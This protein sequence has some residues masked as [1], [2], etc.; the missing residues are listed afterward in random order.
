VILLT[1][2]VALSAAPR[3]LSSAF[4]AEGV[5]RFA[6]RQGGGSVLVEADPNA[7]MVEAIGTPTQWE[8]G[9]AVDATQ[10]AEHVQV[11]VVDPPGMRTCRVD[12]RVVLPPGVQVSIDTG[13]G[14]VH[15]RALEGEVGVR[16]GTG[17][18][19]L[20]DVTGEI[21]VKL[22][23]GGVQGNF[24]GRS[25]TFEVGKGGVHLD[26]LLHPVRATVGLGNIGLTYGLA[27][28]GEVT[29]STGAG[30]ITVLLPPDSPVAVLWGRALGPKRVLL[31][32]NE[33]AP[34]R[35][36]LS[37]GVGSVLV[38]DLTSERGLKRA[39]VRRREGDLR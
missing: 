7:G 9:C 14:G 5:T 12:W 23:T 1:A 4:P 24:S 35:L 39:H 38:D 13:Q 10:Q 33:A 30:A 3:G 27:P 18:L 20:E 36:S 8:E 26:G 15:L 2:A 28:R 34:T 11:T 17:D 25:G 31:P 29:A 6:L 22:G 16:I 19:V 32:E 37:A 21:Q